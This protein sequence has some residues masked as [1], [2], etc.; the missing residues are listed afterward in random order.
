MVF[1]FGRLVLK[2]K[3]LFFVRLHESG[4]INRDF[5]LQGAPHPPSMLMA[6][7]WVKPYSREYA[8]FPA[9]WL[10]NAKFWPTT[11]LY[12]LYITPTF[13]LQT[14]TLAKF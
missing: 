5:V 7:A 14:L 4:D 11:G 13:V 9:P 1:F 12:H 2:R 3:C 10:R 8:A 6:D